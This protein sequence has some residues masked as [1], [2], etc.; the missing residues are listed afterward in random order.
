ML[1]LF[2]LTLSSAGKSASERLAAHTRDKGAGVLGL[3]YW[4]YVL[5]ASAGLG[6][7]LLFPT[8]HPLPW[9][10]VLPPCPWLWRCGLRCLSVGQ[11]S[12]MSYGQLWPQNLCW[13]RERERWTWYTACLSASFMSDCFSS[14]SCSFPCAMRTVCPAGTWEQLQQLPHLCWLTWVRN[15]HWLLQGKLLRFCSYYCSQAD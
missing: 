1:K 10:K 5:R 3:L 14:A 8:I 13:P 6:I 2:R 4:L 9:K 15:E 12:S 7:V 11:D